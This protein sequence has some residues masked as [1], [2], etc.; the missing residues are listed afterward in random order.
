MYASSQESRSSVSQPRGKTSR[1]ADAEFLDAVWDL[2]FEAYGISSTLFVDPEEETQLVFG[3]ASRKMM[4]A[5]AEKA[6]LESVIKAGGGA[7]L[8]NAHDA[9]ERREM[10]D[11]DWRKHRDIHLIPTKNNGVTSLATCWNV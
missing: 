3:F 6:L 8:S 10:I 5:P 2:R 4:A 11:E 7:F 9:V 1:G